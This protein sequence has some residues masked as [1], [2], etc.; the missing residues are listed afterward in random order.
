MVG[1]TPQSVNDPQLTE[2]V[3]EAFAAFTA[4]GVY[5]EQ[6]AAMSAYVSYHGH[7]KQRKP[8][9]QRPR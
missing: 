4:D 8:P 3:E 1:R 7:T 9:V 6:M 5:L 2:M